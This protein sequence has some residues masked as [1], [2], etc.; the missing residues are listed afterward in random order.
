MQT[1]RHNLFSWIVEALILF[2]LFSCSFAV[3]ESDS[4]FTHD[5][6]SGKKLPGGP[7]DGR[8]EIVTRDAQV[9]TW[10]AQISLK[11]NFGTWFE[12]KMSDE[13]SDSSL[14]LNPFRDHLKGRTFSDLLSIYTSAQRAYYQDLTQSLQEHGPHAYENR[15]V[16]KAMQKYRLALRE[17]QVTLQFHPGLK[18]WLTAVVSAEESELVRRGPM[19]L[20]SARELL[21]QFRGL[22][23]GKF[24][25]SITG[26]ANLD[27]LGQIA[28]EK[29]ERALKPSRDTLQAWMDLSEASRRE[30]LAKLPS[31]K[32]IP[33]FMQA[34]MLLG[35]SWD[36]AN[37]DYAKEREEKERQVRLQESLEARVAF[38]PNLFRA[39]EAMAHGA[40]ERGSQPLAWREGGAID[41]LSPVMLRVQREREQN[42]TE[43]L[44][45][46]TA[47]ADVKDPD[48]RAAAEREIKRRRN[49]LLVTK[50]MTEEKAKRY[51]PYLFGDYTYFS[52]KIEEESPGVLNLVFEPTE[53]LKALQTRQAL[54]V[55]SVRIHS[56]DLSDTVYRAANI[57]LHIPITEEE[58]FDYWSRLGP[59][60]PGSAHE[61]HGGF[62]GGL[63]STDLPIDPKSLAKGV[64]LAGAKSGLK[65]A[66][67]EVALDVAK[68]I[69]K[70]AAKLTLK[71]NIQY[72]VRDR[73]MVRSAGLFLADLGEIPQNEFFRSGKEL[74]DAVG[75]KKEKAPNLLKD[76]QLHPLP[77]AQPTGTM[78]ARLDLPSKSGDPRMGPLLAETSPTKI[79]QGAAA[80][81]ATTLAKTAHA[82][83]DAGFP[84]DAFAPIPAEPFS[85][86][87]L[88]KM[89]REPK[90]PLDLPDRDL[91]KELRPHVEYSSTTPWNPAARAEL[92][93]P[94]GPT[95]EI[96]LPEPS[97]ALEPRRFEDLS[98]TE[99]PLPPLEP[100][101]DPQPEKTPQENLADFAAELGLPAETIATLPDTLTSIDEFLK[102]KDPAKRNLL[103]P[104]VAK[105]VV[106]F[107]KFSGTDRIEKL[108]KMREK[109]QA[110]M[111][112]NLAK[113]P[114]V[115]ERSF[116]AYWNAALETALNIKVNDFAI[117]KLFW[118]DL[119]PGFEFGT[120]KKT[121][122]LPSAPVPSKTTPVVNKPAA[123]V[124]QPAQQPAQQPTYQQPQQ[125]PAY[126][127][128]AYQPQQPVYQ[129]PVLYRDA[130]GRYFYA[131]PP[132]QTQP[133][134]VYTGCSNQY[135]TVAP[136]CQPQVRYRRR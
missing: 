45:P 119:Y 107:A 8:V 48:L 80:A 15:D 57:P 20:L 44:K 52:P 46:R 33:L 118:A 116:L 120:N 90:A 101:P 127:Q 96:R 100:V 19:E 28:L 68:D 39:H 18:D 22:K 135:P 43:K 38:S 99:Q 95:P 133:Q 71:D 17:L 54:L 97:A 92:E 125:Q 129:Q 3:A 31:E 87:E 130:Y 23:S 108:K 121:A 69:P 40:L 35:R 115:N 24:S 4:Y 112:D 27:N 104:K 65:S 55:D 7:R 32:A 5:V 53:A 134:P 11:S 61:I 13:T 60:P 123:T 85:L 78:I 66:V 105:L 98:A 136:R 103:L 113:Y 34:K 131:Y 67:K 73:E 1:S 89:D 81:P 37:P 49:Q 51:A 111:K 58:R 14:D 26:N 41:S 88:A 102:E 126:Q 70:Q 72:G 47:L 132:V 124:A 91:R 10:I 82:D 50:D 93:L 9:Q 128:P 83:P 110:E 106:S 76:P 94:K 122:A 75:G 12:S 59:N 84:K 64:F 79:P 86:A 62:S 2:V 42:L 25:A 74:V 117:K 16:A 30:Q 63:E 77:A 29:I 56:D 114:G 6:I 36:Y 109:L 21:N